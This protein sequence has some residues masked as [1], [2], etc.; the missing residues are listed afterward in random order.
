[1]T[2]LVTLLKA[3][4]HLRDCLEADWFVAPLYRLSILL[5]RCTVQWSYVMAHIQN[6]HIREDLPCASLFA[7]LPSFTSLHDDRMQFDFGR[8][9]RLEPP[10]WD[11]DDDWIP[12]LRNLRCRY[13][14][15]RSGYRYS[16]DSSKTLLLTLSL[17]L[18]KTY[19]NSPWECRK[20]IFVGCAYTV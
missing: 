20:S 19:V 2:K 18:R 17:S 13:L 3:K 1:M 15:C 10:K 5:Y 11:D 6:R 14:C 16:W 4:E 12:L 8:F 7:R 9:R